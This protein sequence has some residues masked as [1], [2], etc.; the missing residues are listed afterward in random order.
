MVFAGVVLSPLALLAQP[1][2][3]PL[4]QVKMEIVKV[5]FVDKVM[6]TTGEWKAPDTQPPSKIAVVTVK[7]KK[8]AEMGVTLATADLT[9]HYL[10]AKGYDVTP[11]DG[12]SNFSR[13][14]DDERV[15]VVTRS[16]HSGCPMWYKVQSGAS[17]T[18]ATEFYF[19]ALFARMETD[20][21]DMW[22]FVGQP[23]NTAPK[24]AQ[25]SDFVEKWP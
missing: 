5:R 25:A 16:K 12:L 8:P 4:N 17:T 3:L 7:V 20:T 10:H 6:H 21:S 2:Y 18:Q 19:D 1:A 11:C 23:G 15:M 24:R 14:L 22:I 9:L 13:Q